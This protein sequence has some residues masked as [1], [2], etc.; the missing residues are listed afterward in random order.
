MNVKQLLL[1]Y[2]ND[3]FDLIVCSNLAILNDRIHDDFVEFGASGTVL[4]NN[5]SYRY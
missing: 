3:F 1:K 2:E 4:I 5:R